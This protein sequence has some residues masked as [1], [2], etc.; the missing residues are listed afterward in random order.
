[1]SFG[2]PVFK[3]VKNWEEQHERAALHPLPGPLRRRLAFPPPSLAHPA[4]CRRAAAG[5]ARSA[6]LP[7]T[8]GRP[9]HVQPQ[10]PRGR[11]IRSPPQAASPSRAKQL[12]PSISPQLRVCALL[13][14][15]SA[16]RCQ[17]LLPLPPRQPPPKPPAPPSSAWVNARF[18][19]RPTLLLNQADL[20]PLKP[21]Q[22][23]SC[24]T[25]ADLSFPHLFPID[26]IQFRADLV[27]FR[28]A[29]VKNRSSSSSRSSRSVLP[30]LPTPPLFTAGH[31]APLS[32]AL[33]APLACAHRRPAPS[34]TPR[35]T[36]P[37]ASR[38][39]ASL[40][41]ARPPG[42]PSPAQA[43]A[44]RANRIGRNA[45][46][47]TRLATAHAAPPSI[48]L[49]PG[50]APPHCRAAAGQPPPPCSTPQIEPHARDAS[51]APARHLQQSSPPSRLGPITSTAPAAR[52]PCLTR[53]ASRGA[54]FARA[55]LDLCHGQLFLFPL[56][57]RPACLAAA[58]L[59]TINNS[60]CR[61]NRK[62]KLAS[63]FPFIRMQQFTLPRAHPY[64]C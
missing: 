36:I 16:A 19:T 7:L 55:P 26:S 34:S 4:I 46:L 20:H 25:S 15:A 64:S 2:A 11:P 53:S 35:R 42:Q 45:L 56:T 30:E 63:Q 17:P 32:A 47:A 31:D 5:P 38:R 24:V 50:P 29:L 54:P 49:R 9:T 57:L 23:A 27:N 12:R 14:A 40:P 60:N 61:S 51:H 13:L 33:L 6:L 58:P 18:R 10:P 43:A 1:M 22:L 8:G 21:G 39:P 52:S 28:S 59:V 37:L 3:I 62:H 48:C 41:P 44:P